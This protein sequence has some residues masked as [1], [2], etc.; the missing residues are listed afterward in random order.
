[1]TASVH[2]CR[3]CDTPHDEDDDIRH[4]TDCET[5]ICTTC[6]DW[7]TIPASHRTP[8][9]APPVDGSFRCGFCQAGYNPSRHDPAAS[10]RQPLTVIPHPA[11]P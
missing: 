11:R 1:M 7:L 10:G 3:E 9:P 5:W 2:P 6:D 4:C 8:V